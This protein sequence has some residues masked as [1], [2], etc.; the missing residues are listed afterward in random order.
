MKKLIAL[1]I[2]AF[3]VLGISTAF[4]ADSEPVTVDLTV[5]SEFSIDVNTAALNLG[6]IAQGSSSSAST[7]AVTCY[8]NTGGTWQVDVSGPALTHTDTVTTIASNPNLKIYGFKTAG[9]GLVAVGFATAAA[10]PASDL[11]LYNSAALDTGTDTFNL[12]VPGISVPSDQ[13]SGDYNTT[14]T[15]T[16]HE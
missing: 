14:I 15:L 7:I 3:L 8:S 2:A 10:L 16:M 6:T 11:V 5:G 13:K 4:A 12:E 9:D 1:S